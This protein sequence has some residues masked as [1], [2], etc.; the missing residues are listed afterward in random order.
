M[1]STLSYARRDIERAINH[2][3]KAFD[4]VKWI[5]EEYGEYATVK[6]AAVTFLDGMAGAKSLLEQLHTA[7]ADPAGNL[8]PPDTF[9]DRYENDQQREDAVVELMRDAAEIAARMDQPC[10]LRKVASNI[11]H[12]GRRGT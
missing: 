3:E 11:C 4:R 10:D 6:A 5:A 2:V 9:A 8:Q 1:A 12:I 7:C